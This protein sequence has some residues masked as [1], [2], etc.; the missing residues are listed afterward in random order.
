MNDIIDIN[1][2]KIWSPDPEL[3]ASAQDLLSKKEW[4]H[5]H[6]GITGTRPSALGIEKYR[7]GNPLHK[8]FYGARVPPQVP[9]DSSENI[10]WYEEQLHRCIYG[11]EY[12]GTRITGD[13]YW[14]LNFTP[15]LVA[16]LDKYGYA[17]P[18]FD[19]QLP[20]FSHVYD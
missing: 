4:M 18:N 12:K 1:G 8:N 16:K 10:E 6:N 13:Y 5:K 17:T 14:F 11:Y 19:I 20:Y 7:Y 9:L 3:C 15:F 2:N